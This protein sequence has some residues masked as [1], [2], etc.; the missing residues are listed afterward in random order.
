M[1]Y[2]FDID[3]GSPNLKNDYGSIINQMLD[4]FRFIN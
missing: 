3:V 4:T 1:I 2:G